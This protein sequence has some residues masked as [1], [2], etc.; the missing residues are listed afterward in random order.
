MNDLRTIK[1][2]GG[3]HD[4]YVGYITMMYIIL[5]IK[6]LQ[7]WSSLHLQIKKYAG[8]VCLCYMAAKTINIFTIKSII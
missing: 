6:L 4:Y 7:K 3:K 8:H 5:K 2:K 1:I